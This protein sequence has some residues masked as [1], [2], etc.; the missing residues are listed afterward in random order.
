MLPKENRQT[1]LA[2][3][4]WLCMWERTF[5]CVHLCVYTCVPVMGKRT[6]LLLWFSRFPPCGSQKLFSLQQTQELVL[7]MHATC[8]FSKRERHTFI[9]ILNWQES[10]I[11][12]RNVNE[13]RLI[14]LDK[15]EAEWFSPYINE[16]MV[17]KKKKKWYS[18]SNSL[19]WPSRLSSVWAYWLV[20][21]EP[22]LF[23]LEVF[24]HSSFISTHL[25]PP[26]PSLV[27]VP[28]TS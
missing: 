10:R 25:C 20:Q 18:N 19:A 22:A 23:G 28:G 1:H 21:E 7:S 5:R 15:K 27:S 12:I 14:T 16:R 8:S 2:L 24:S 13:Q 26:S 3:F 4:P 9:C 6:E 11:I 17:L